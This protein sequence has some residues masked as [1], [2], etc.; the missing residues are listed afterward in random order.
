MNDTVLICRQRHLEPSCFPPPW[1]RIFLLS[2][3]VKVRLASLWASRS[4]FSFISA[5]HLSTEPHGITDAYRYSLL[6]L[7]ITAC[8]QKEKQETYLPWLLICRSSHS[9]RSALNVFTLSVQSTSIW[10]LIHQQCSVMR[11][12]VQLCVFCTNRKHIR[13][14]SLSLVEDT[15]WCN[16]F[17]FSRHLSKHSHAATAHPLTGKHMNTTSGEHRRRGK[18]LKVWLRGMAT[19]IE[20]TRWY[21]PGRRSR[22]V[23]HF[24]V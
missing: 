14:E 7:T 13:P 15:L 3:A 8:I 20:E 1:D 21:A 12:T 9:K 18:C 10:E 5:F 23:F 17:N 24:D 4:S 22:S 6:S 19:I 16:C 2:A 11:S